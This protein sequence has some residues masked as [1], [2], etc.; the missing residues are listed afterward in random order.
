MST[1]F[2]SVGLIVLMLAVDFFTGWFSPILGPA[3]MISAVIAIGYFI[4]KQAT[5]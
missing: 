1:F 3:V 4:L 2:F 5:R